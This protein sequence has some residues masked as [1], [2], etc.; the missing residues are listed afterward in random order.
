MTKAARRLLNL[1]HLAV[2]RE[3]ARRGSVAAAAR[4]VFMS[5]PAATQAVAAVEE[6]F[7]T[8]LF[9]RKPTGMLLTAAGRTCLVRVERALEELHKGAPE[10]PRATARAS[11]RRA[12]AV[13]GDERDPLA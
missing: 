9:G 12:N 10:A 4:A 2:F 13:P 6:Y 8:P 11:A 1:R 3:V 5:Q 7:G